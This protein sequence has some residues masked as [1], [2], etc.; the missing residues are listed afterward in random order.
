M[1][2][3]FRLAS[4][5]FGITFTGKVSSTVLP[6]MVTAQVTVATPIETAFTVPSADT[7][8]TDGLLLRQI[9]LAPS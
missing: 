6:S 3:T 9:A 7:L 5:R 8:T 2:P 4:E 1:P